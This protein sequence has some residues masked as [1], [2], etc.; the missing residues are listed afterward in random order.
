MRG[1]RQGRSERSDHRPTPNNV[2]TEHARNGAEIQRRPDGR[3]RE[4]RTANGAVIHH[5]LNGSRRVEVER[6][7]HSRIVAERGGH[8][9]V[10]HPYMYRGHEFA[11]RTYYV[12]G[13]AYDRFYGR[14][15][16]RPGVFVEVY[17]PVR[18]YPVGYYGWAYNP[19]VAPVAYPWGWTVAANPWYGYYGYYFTPA[20]VYP[21]ASLWL[22]DYLI[23]QSLESAYAAQAA[24][25]AQAANAAQAAI[26]T[27]E[28][29]AQI[30]AEVQL[31]IA[32][33]NAEAQANAQNAE[34]DPSQSSIKRLVI[35][36][37]PHVFVVGRALDLVDN[38]GSECAVSEGDVLL[39][40]GPRSPDVETPNLSVLTNKG[41][42]EC[43]KGVQVSVAMADLQDMQ[44]H[45]REQIDAGLEKLHS[46]QGKNG[47]PA[48]PAAAAAPPVQAAFAASAPPPDP[49]AAAQINQQAQEAER[50]EQESL[51][52]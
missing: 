51:A 47:I 25:A 12:N 34:M 15:E 48:A 42:I 44:N 40:S 4:V 33:E 13:R 37:K 21:T 31:Q 20:P 18:Y 26:I 36:Q 5:G 16:Y 52:G 22:A 30:A 28:V 9:Y 10:Q 32:R 45:L 50:A 23:S 7:D 6:A 27:A 17:S 24:A 43:R 41:G 2:R 49:D 3:P 1:D 8:G 11:H 39:L 19:W 29:K 35:D 14:Y 46:N 38:T